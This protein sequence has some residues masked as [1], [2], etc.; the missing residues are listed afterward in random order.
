MAA[1]NPL[2]I[3]VLSS[4]TT[5]KKLPMSAIHSTVMAILARYPNRSPELTFV[6]DGQNADRIS[7]A[8]RLLDE[9][10][11][12][13][14]LLKYGCSILPVGNTVLE[15][16]ASIQKRLS[17]GSSP[18]TTRTIVIVLTGPEPSFRQ[19][20]LVRYA[21]RHNPDDLV[22][23]DASPAH[24]GLRRTLVYCAGA[25]LARTYA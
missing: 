12:T 2:H 9:W 13:T 15:Q 1:A 23:Y 4:E 19:Y 18:T 22:I 7:S 6:G 11:R 20:L 25:L 14:D 24:T 17:V 21:L 3:F 10:E 16:C 8:E 5:G